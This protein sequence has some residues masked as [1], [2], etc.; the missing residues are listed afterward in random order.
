M[1]ELDREQMVAVLKA[2]FGNSRF[3][4][5]QKSAFQNLLDQW[6][7]L[8]QFSA[9]IRA[10]AF[11]LVRDAVEPAQHVHINWM[12]AV[13]KIA[14][15]RTR[16]PQGTKLETEVC[17]SPG[18]SC[19]DLIVRALKEAEMSADICVFTITD[20]SISEQIIA[21]HRRGVQVRIITDNEKSYD[22]GS[23]IAEF[24][25]AGI[26]VRIDETDKHMH[27]KFAIFDQ[28]AVLT[29]SYNWT[30][31]AASANE[32]N[33]VYLGDPFVVNAFREEFEKL[34]PRMTAARP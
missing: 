19:R 9:E 5:D 33:I 34:L 24:A 26:D 17:F 15:G 32:E 21:A 29:G 8:P 13:L 22:F 6:R 23:D 30:R 25:R 27:H 20:N 31:S 7:H 10:A 28:K 16:L 14:S 4:R 3:S 18:R 12:E 2:A 1:N 11:D